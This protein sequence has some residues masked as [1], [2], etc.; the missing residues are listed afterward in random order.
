MNRIDVYKRQMYSSEDLERFYF[1]YQT[2]ALPHGESLQSFC[3]KPVSYTHLDVYKRQGRRLLTRSILE[4]IK[5]KENI[6]LQC[7]DSCLLYTSRCV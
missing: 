7:T 3:V 2:E 5:E 1:Q 6:F 4:R